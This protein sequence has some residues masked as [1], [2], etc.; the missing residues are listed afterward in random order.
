MTLHHSWSHNCYPEKNVTLNYFMILEAAIMLAPIKE[1]KDTKK[2]A[3]EIRSF[4]I[5]TRM[6]FFCI[7]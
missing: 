6:Q 4:C 5:R 7:K 1:F 3:N 2:F